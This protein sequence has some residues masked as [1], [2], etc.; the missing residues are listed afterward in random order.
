VRI[1]I[2]GATGA[3]GRALVTQ[4]ITQGH[5]VTAFVRTPAKFDV[6]HGGLKVV[7]GDIT[8]VAA[9]ERALFGQDAVFCTLGA[10]TP[11]KR[12][13]TLVKGVD[14]IVRAMQRGGPRRLIYLSFLGVRGGREQ[15]SLLGRYVVAPFILR[16]IVADHEAK[17][18]IIS[19][20]RLDWT[21]IRPPRLTN[22]PSTGGAYR[23]GID[24]KASSVIP[25]ISRADVAHFM[26]TQLDERRY[27][28]KAPAVMY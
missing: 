27:L 13:Q 28:H 26:L 20:S 18:N 1:V 14:N 21:I 23:H 12:D 11:L 24:I 17:E 15:L 5:Q 9:V 3:T 19:Q 22:G 25:M 10:A 8:D 2:F 16:N 7:Q 6:K 4:A